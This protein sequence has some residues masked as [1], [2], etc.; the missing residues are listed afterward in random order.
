MA[1]DA[2]FLA[3][4]ARELRAPDFFLAFLVDHERSQRSE[5]DKPEAPNELAAGEAR[6]VIGNQTDTACGVTRAHEFNAVDEDF[7]L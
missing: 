6:D 1:G 7:S 4:F 5:A 2:L 3:A